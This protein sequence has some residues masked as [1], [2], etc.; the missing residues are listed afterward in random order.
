M[1]QYDDGPTLRY[2]EGHDEDEH[3]FLTTEPFD[4]AEWERFEVLPE[5]FTDAWAV[6]HRCRSRADRI[7]PLGAGPRCSRG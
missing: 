7:R 5:V 1:E 6:G 3:G 4:A 2:S